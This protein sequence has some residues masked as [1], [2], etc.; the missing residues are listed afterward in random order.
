MFAISALATDLMEEPKLFD[1]ILPPIKAVTRFII[2]FVQENNT[3]IYFLVTIKLQAISVSLNIEMKAREM[4]PS[5]RRSSRS[6]LRHTHSEDRHNHRESEVRP[7]RH[8]RECHHDHNRDRQ[9]VSNERGRRAEDRGSRSDHHREHCDSKNRTGN[10]RE[11]ERDCS[12]HNGERSV[13]RHAEKRRD[14]REDRISHSRHDRARNDKRA[15]SPEGNHR[16]N[17]RDKRSRNGLNDRE[18]HESKDLNEIRRDKPAHVRPPSEAA[19]GSP[20]DY[21][22]DPLKEDEF[23]SYLNSYIDVEFLE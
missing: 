20:R 10:Q 11:H 15:R 9:L 14:H 23:E 17:G 13:N 16:E 2:S 7:S 1:V 4:T 5:R 19:I 22:E 12:R 3:L 8:D 6:P 21:L 18:S